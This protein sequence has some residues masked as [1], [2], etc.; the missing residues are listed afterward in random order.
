MTLHILFL[1][2]TISKRKRNPEAVL[3]EEKVEKIHTEYK[4]LRHFMRHY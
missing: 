2:I 1:T 3:Q 4:D